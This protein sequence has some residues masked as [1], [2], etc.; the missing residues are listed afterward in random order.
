MHL[1]AGGA[2]HTAGGCLRTPVLGLPSH[3]LQSADGARHGDPEQVPGAFRE[4]T[5]PGKH[6]SSL[7]SRARLCTSCPDLS[8]LHL[9]TPR[10]TKLL[11]AS[12][13]L[14]PT[15]VHRGLLKAL[16]PRA[17]GSLPGWQ[18][19]HALGAGQVSP[20]E[21]HRVSGPRWAPGQDRE[22]E[23]AQDACDNLVR[24]PGRPR[25]LGVRR[26]AAS[27][28]VGTFVEGQV[29][30]P[31]GCHRPGP[32][33]GAA[34][35]EGD[36]SSALSSCQEEA[37]GHDLGAAQRFTFLFLFLNFFWRVNVLNRR[38]LTL[39][40]E[41]GGSPGPGDGERAQGA[42]SGSGH[43]PE[44]TQAHRLLCRF[45]AGSC[46]TPRSFPF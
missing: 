12:P 40:L 30:L 43:F 38:Q 11:A 39:V 2:T 28:A 24:C 9:R 34:G 3:G 20:G 17:H 1:P 4:R 16:H 5:G 44:C 19:S 41:S 18:E 27:W 46:K 7:G 13:H 45:S 25:S 21:G 42:S 14:C 26:Q 6:L 29:R 31:G 15:P 32:G 8:S 22:E 10:M 23:G 35:R 37:G 36:R 33:R